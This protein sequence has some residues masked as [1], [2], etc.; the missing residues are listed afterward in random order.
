MAAVLGLLVLAVTLLPSAQAAVSGA[1][2]P[3]GTTS[4]ATLRFARNAQPS[5]S[6]LPIQST[7]GSAPR[8][9]YSVRLSPTAVSSTIDLRSTTQ[10]GTCRSTDI[11]GENNPQGECRGSAPYDFEPRFGWRIV[12]A[13]SPTDPRGQTVVRNWRSTVCPN[14][15]HHCPVGVAVDG[16][17]VAGAGRYLN[18]VAT[19]WNPA[20]QSGQ[21]LAISHGVMQ[22]I[23]RLPGSPPL[24]RPHVTRP[25]GTVFPASPG[26]AKAGKEDERPALLFSQPVTVRRG[27]VLDIR[28]QL[29][30]QIRNSKDN[31]PF[32]ATYVFLTRDRRSVV[33]PE[34]GSPFAAFHR[35]GQNCPTTCAF[36]RLGA[37]R[38]PVAGAM[39]VN[40][41][42][43]A[44]DHEYE[45][46]G[47]VAYDGH[48]WVRKR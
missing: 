48:L 4:S 20:A 14:V 36:T 28:T 38:S 31:A 40:V 45:T 19:G 23:Q 10:L 22:V 26:S 16:Y 43:L 8:V 42:A 44:R 37:I 34:R 17:R 1:S 12:L 39:H 46:Q 7:T 5:V 3:V 41:V 2:V 21:V 29:S 35:A 24:V 27:D 33:A 18:F 25:L 11:S 32:L 47:S 13:R 9:L 15:V 6:K 30:F